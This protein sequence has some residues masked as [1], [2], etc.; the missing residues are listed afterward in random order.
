[1]AVGGCIASVPTSAWA[2]SARI[3]DPARVNYS[4]LLGVAL[5]APEVRQILTGADP[6]VLLPFVSAAATGT[7]PLSLG[8][9]AAERLVAVRAYDAAESLA[10][11]ERVSLEVTTP[12]GDGATVL[13]PLRSAIEGLKLAVALRNV[14]SPAAIT[15]ALDSIAFGSATSAAEVLF[16][17]TLGKEAAD[18]LRVRFLT[19]GSEAER[20]AYFV[21]MIRIPDEGFIPI[22]SNILARGTGAYGSLGGAERTAARGLV[23]VGTRAAVIALRDALAEAES[24]HTYVAFETRYQRR[25]IPEF[26]RGQVVVLTGHTIEEWLELLRE[27]PT[28]PASAEPSPAVWNLG[29][30]R[31][32]PTSRAQVSF[33]LGNIEGGRDPR[34]LVLD[35]IRLNGA[36]PALELRPHNM[37]NTRWT[38]PWVDIVFRQRD[39]IELVPMEATQGQAFTAIVTGTLT[40]GTRIRAEAQVRLVGQR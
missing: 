9:L 31:D 15:V 10:V 17:R 28:I 36:M 33:E 4:T 2:Q 20:A 8:I 23:V 5:D 35:S 32:V 40:D 24:L 13:W 38:G 29:W 7:G 18:S 1:M 6:Q 27:T 22:L 30:R 11:L 16:L 19:A 34:T 37:G 26:W 21:A 12:S 25:S 3:G 39:A 14:S